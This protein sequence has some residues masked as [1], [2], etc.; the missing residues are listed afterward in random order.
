MASDLLRGA[1]VMALVLMAAVSAQAQAPHRHLASTSAEELKRVYLECDR[2]ATRTLL[3]LGDAAH[4]SMVGEELKHR[5]F[6]G[7]FE[8]L[9]AW[10]REQKS[11]AAEAGRQSAA[12]EQ[13]WRAP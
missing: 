3:D 12:Q 1:A 8:R 11:I 9:L 6:G 5:I 13:G 7:D 2:F 10:W 4:C